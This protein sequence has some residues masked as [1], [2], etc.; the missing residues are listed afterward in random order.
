MTVVYLRKNSEGII[1]F[2]P[3]NKPHLDKYWAQRGLIHTENTETGDYTVILCRDFLV[4]LK[5]LNDM[6]GNSREAIVSGFMDA[7]E[8]KRNRDF[9]D[10]GVALVRTARGQGSPE[11][12]GVGKELLR[13][14]PKSVVVPCKLSQRF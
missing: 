4:R 12:E 8:Y 10:N 1:H 3:K 2:G 11:V 7:Q 14:A 6:L 9:I 5:A 13:R